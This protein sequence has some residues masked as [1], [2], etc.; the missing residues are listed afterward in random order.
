LYDPADEPRY[1]ELAARAV[2]ALDRMAVDLRRL[3]AEP[4]GGDSPDRLVSV[5]VTASGAVTDVR[6]RP[7]A[8][9]RYNSVR[10]GEVVT[11]TLRDTQQR[12]RAAYERAAAELVPE[13]IAECERLARR[14][15]E[16]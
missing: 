12:A 1:V 10:L 15:G 8:L 2:A 7:A 6:V 11:R 14:D 9:R 3:A 5:R 4:V 13:E 16:A